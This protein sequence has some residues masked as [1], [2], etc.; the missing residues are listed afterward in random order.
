MHVA[1]NLCSACRLVG[2]DEKADALA[3]EAHA[4]DPDV[5]ELKERAA[6][7]HMR[8]RNFDKA[9]ELANEVAEEGGSE[10]ALFAAGIAASSQEWDLAK[11]WA[12]KCHDTVKDDVQKAC[13]ADLLLLAEYRTV[14]ALAAIA[15][16]EF[17]PPHVHLEH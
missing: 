2:E 7:A 1:A 17:P 3:L 10:E 13:A 14:D 4:L 12:Q 16:A 9:T 11:K 5:D 15:R 6:F 8:R